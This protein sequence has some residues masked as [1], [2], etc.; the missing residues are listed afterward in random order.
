LIDSLALAKR[1]KID[2]T[3]GIYE[4]F[5]ALNV[6]SSEFGVLI[7]MYDLTFMNT[8]TSIYDG[9]IYEQRRR[10]RDIHIKI[11]KPFLNLI[12]GTTP[13]SLATFMPEGAWDQGFASRT[14]FVYSDESI[15]QPIF[16]LPEAHTKY[17]SLLG[18]LR[19]DIKAIGQNYGL[20]QW[21]PAAAEAISRWHLSGCE[22]VPNHPRLQHYII[23]R[24]AHLIKLC[25]VA[26]A[27]R[28]SDLL[29]TVQDLD[30]ALNWLIE[31]EAAM[32]YLFRGISAGGDDLTIRE[33]LNWLE[34]RSKK[35]GLPVPRYDFI[36]YLKSRV[37]MALIEQTISVMLNSKMIEATPG[38]PVTYA[39][40]KM[41]RSG[42]GA[43]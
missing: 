29:I 33:A 17:A 31:A 32:P 1:A 41:I 14:I 27:Q 42:S 8:L 7:P 35:T 19:S 12:G 2:P 5:N 18:D 28:C 10:G 37:K 16:S 26:H 20:L 39:P 3:L 6:V 25:V 30:T 4:E 36:Y 34:D 13:S 40:S 22:P 24:I 23:R 38:N 15:L 21:E 9:E 43:A 11:E